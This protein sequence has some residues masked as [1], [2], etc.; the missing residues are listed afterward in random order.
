MNQ[1]SLKVSLISL[2]QRL[3][4]I[5]L[6]QRSPRLA[7]VPYI[8]TILKEQVKNTVTFS[9]LLASDSLRRWWARP[10]YHYRLWLRKRPAV[11]HKP[12]TTLRE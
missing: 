6:Q 10:R 5:P 12:D 1:V 9:L 2:F 7:V 4:L 8:L 11:L 3:W